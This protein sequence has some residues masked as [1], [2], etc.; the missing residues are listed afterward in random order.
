MSTRNGTSR[1][2]RCEGDPISGGWRWRVGMPGS[3]G[4]RRS[5][6]CSLRTRTA[7]E[8]LAGTFVHDEKGLSALCR[9]LVRLEVRL[10]AIERPDGMLVE[11]C[12][13]RD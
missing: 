2:G 12:L 4:R 13:T 9:T 6:T 11:R 1:S 10:V 3:T 8:V 5:T 7:A